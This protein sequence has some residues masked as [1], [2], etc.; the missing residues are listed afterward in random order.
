MRRFTEARQN[1]GDGSV[2]RS[3]AALR[4]PEAASFNPRILRRIATRARGHPT[5][6]TDFTV[7]DGR[8]L[9]LPTFMAASGIG[10]KAPR[11]AVGWRPLAAFK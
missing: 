6:V 7:D 8:L 10:G 11:R 5:K 4:P 3:E 9:A 1:A 2:I